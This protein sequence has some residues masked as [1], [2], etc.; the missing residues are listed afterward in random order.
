MIAI[1]D[2]IQRYWG[3]PEFH[4]QVRDYRDLSSEKLPNGYAQL[5]RYLAILQVRVAADT[6]PTD[7]L[8]ENYIQT[9]QVWLLEQGTR[10]RSWSQGRPG[11]LLQDFL[12]RIDNADITIP[13][14]LKLPERYQVILR[15]LGNAD[16]QTACETTLKALTVRFAE[17]GGDANALS[18]LVA[19]FAGSLPEDNQKL[20]FLMLANR[21][22]AFEPQLTDL[23]KFSLN[24]DQINVGGVLIGLVCEAIPLNAF[25][26]G[27]PGV[28]AIAM[29]VAILAFTPLFTYLYRLSS[30]RAAHA[31][32]LTE[33][34]RMIY[35]L[36]YHLPSDHAAIDRMSTA[37][38]ARLVMDWR[39]QN[40]DTHR[41]FTDNLERLQYR[42]QDTVHLKLLTQS[43]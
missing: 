41:W 7:P 40:H 15:H 34:L 19:S 30:I 2:A 29:G 37:E 24:L 42:F 38:L 4:R 36:A 33:G 23:E 21:L 18:Q 8:L 9:A 28:S 39:S 17:L 25:L 27:L 10:V 26:W 11:P 5:Y 16:L 13:T 31:R 20:L 14:H 1:L 32:W 43:S 3:D 6:T 35:D 22:A 12:L